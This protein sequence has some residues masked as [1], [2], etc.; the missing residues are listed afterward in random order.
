[1]D[2]YR[3][4]EGSCVITAAAAAIR[5]V[6]RV[7]HCVLL[8]RKRDE[9]GIDGKATKRVGGRIRRGIGGRAFCGCW[10]LT[11]D[12]IDIFLLWVEEIPSTKWDFEGLCSKLDFGDNV[13][14][15]QDNVYSARLK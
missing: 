8:L 14:I 1:M 13:N 5:V 3:H 6:V 11:I 4:A 15:C 7:G 2:A 10:W 9:R 12:E